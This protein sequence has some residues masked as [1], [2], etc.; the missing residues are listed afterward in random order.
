MENFKRI[1]IFYRKAHVHN[2]YY[3]LHEDEY[4]MV[5]LNE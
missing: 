3:I 4:S 5:R 2:L 1:E